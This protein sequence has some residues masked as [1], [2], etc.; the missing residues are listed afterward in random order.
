[1][2]V[3]KKNIAINIS[4]KAKIP[5]AEASIFLDAFLSCIICNSNIS[6]IKIPSFGTFSNNLSKSRIGRNPKTMEIYEIR[7]VKKL[8]FSS[9]Y[10]IRAL[11]N[12]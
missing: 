1:M 2:T 5:V 12:S 9:S 11:I 7:P 4:K 3:N 8:T 10:K 6:S